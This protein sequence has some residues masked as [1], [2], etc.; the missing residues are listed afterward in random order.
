MFKYSVYVFL[1]SFFLLH[2]HANATIIYENDFQSGDVTGWESPKSGPGQIGTDDTGNNK[3]LGLFGDYEVSGIPF[4]DPF[5]GDVVSLNLGGKAAGSYNIA[6]DFYAIN[7]WDGNT[8]G[9]GPDIFSL[10]INNTQMFSSWFA[11]DGSNSGGFTAEDSSDLFFHY[12]LDGIKYTV[13]SKKFSIDYDFYHTGAGDM[14]FS[15]T[16]F[17]SQANQTNSN[18]GFADEPWALDNVRVASQGAAPVPEPTTML[19]F[20]TGLAGLAAASRRKKAC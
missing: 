5:N 17:P 20:G 4:P 8:E 13:Q 9:V 16:G 6:F 12:V 18:T 19:L 3:F 10:T 11:S 1:Y 14:V 15:F 2:G 7:T